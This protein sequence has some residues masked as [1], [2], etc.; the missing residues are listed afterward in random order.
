MSP[1]PG[2]RAVGGGLAR[3]VSVAVTSLARTVAVAFAALFLLTLVAFAACS[4]EWAV[5]EE[6]YRAG[7]LGEMQQT[8]ARLVPAGTDADE[9]RRPLEARGFVCEAIARADDVRWPG[10][11]SSQGYE[12]LPA[13]ADVRVCSR[14]NAAGFGGIGLAAWTV[15]LVHTDEAVSRVIV[16]A[17]FRAPL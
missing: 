9:A 13:G 7:S 10:P 11:N 2:P 14:R 1:L 5:R 8:L 3:I 17:N 6:T 16:R 15:A 12:P 4:I